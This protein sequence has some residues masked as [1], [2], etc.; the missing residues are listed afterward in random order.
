M[1]RSALSLGTGIVCLAL[2]LAGS[3]PCRAEVILG[4]S[5]LSDPLLPYYRFS[6]GYF[7]PPS[8]TVNNPSF[9]LPTLDLSGVGWR[10]PGIVAGGLAGTSR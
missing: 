2:G 9:Y 10:L 7:D 3:Q 4:P 5:Q 6:S 1:N 8:G